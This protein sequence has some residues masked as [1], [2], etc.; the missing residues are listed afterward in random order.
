MGRSL[1]CTKKTIACGRLHPP[2]EMEKNKA[3]GIQKYVVWYMLA[4][5]YFE[6]IDKGPAQ[7]NIQYSLETMKTK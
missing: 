3:S 7:G 6:I 2:I 5:G 1:L 4:D